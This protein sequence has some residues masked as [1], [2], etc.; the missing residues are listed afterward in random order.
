[1]LHQHVTNLKQESWNLQEKTGK[2]RQDLEKYCEETEQDG[3]RLCLRIKNMEKKENES[4]DK[5]LE[6]VKCLFSEASI[7]IPDACIDCAHCVSRTDD[8]VIVCFTTFRHCTMFYRKR[9]ELKDGVKVHLDLTK[10]RLDLLIKASKYVN[11]LSNV[12]FL[13]ADVNS[14]LKI[15]FANNS[16]SFFDSM[17]DLISRTEGFP[18]N[19]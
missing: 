13:Y 7:N 10:A 12:G 11:S 1:M 4:S 5:F 14:R 18:N 6:A 17:D 3:R 15:H 2:D 9:K 8:T 16:G 19:I